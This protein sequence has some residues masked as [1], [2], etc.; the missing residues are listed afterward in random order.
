MTAHGRTSDAARAALADHPGWSGLLA[1][2]TEEFCRTE[3]YANAVLVCTS[4][5]DDEATARI[6]LVP[7]GAAQPWRLNRIP[8][9][10][11]RPCP[12]EPATHRHMA[13]VCADIEGEPGPGD[14]IATAEQAY[15][16]LGATELAGVVA[17]F[18]AAN[19]VG[20]P[21]RYWTGAREGEGRTSVT[22]TE[23]QVLSGHTPVVWVEG[24]GACIALTHVQP[25]GGAA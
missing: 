19:P 10:Q 15:R 14:P 4:L 12:D 7:S 5:P 22:R 6:N 9:A 2:T 17:A 13:F 16:E 18:N 24:H 21:V 11:P 20:T 3:E 25:V 23:A 1:Q 8:S